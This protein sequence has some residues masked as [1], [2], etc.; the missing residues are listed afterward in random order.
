MSTNDIVSLIGK[1]NELVVVAKGLESELIAVEWRP[2]DQM[3]GEKFCPRCGE[4]ECNGHARSCIR[5]AAL[6][7]FRVVLEK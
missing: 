3:I 5:Q 4:Y 6:A 2:C 7:A 1:Y